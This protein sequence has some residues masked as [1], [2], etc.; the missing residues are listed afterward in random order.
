MVAAITERDESE[1]NARLIAAA[2]ELLESLMSVIGAFAQ[3]TYGDKEDQID[4]T[5]EAIDKVKPLIERLTQWLKP[6]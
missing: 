4:H 2:P 6:A 1:A 3:P 5:Y